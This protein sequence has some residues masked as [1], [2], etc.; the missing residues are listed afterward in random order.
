MKLLCNLTAINMIYLWFPKIILIFL[1]TVAMTKFQLCF[2][3]I[4]MSSIRDFIPLSKLGE[5]T[6]STVYKVRRSRSTNLR[7]QKSQ[8]ESTF[9]KRKRKCTQLD[10][11]FSIHRL[12]LH[13][14]IQRCFLRWNHQRP[15]HR[16]GVCRY[17]QRQI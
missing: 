11:N 7:T 2:I 8:N 15:V 13:H 1:K 6:Y 3:I 16:H 17:N 9:H 5:G 14:L 12:P 10:Q 4:I